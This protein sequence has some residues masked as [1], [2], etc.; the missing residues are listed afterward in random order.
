MAQIIASRG[1]EPKVAAAQA[2]GVPP[3]GKLHTKNDGGQ[4]RVQCYTPPVKA[5]PGNVIKA[6]VGGGV[7]GSK[8]SHENE[9]PF[10][11][12]LAEA[13][14]RSFCPDGG[15]VLD[16]FSGSGTTCAVAQRWGRRW[17]AID[18]R[19][20]QVDLTKRRIAEVTEATQA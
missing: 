18:T 9:A 1:A 4:M 7:M 20:S 17:L 10:P 8:L 12:G 2:N 16:P 15:I 19:E 3:G 6:I 13:I 5:N 11:E 14:I